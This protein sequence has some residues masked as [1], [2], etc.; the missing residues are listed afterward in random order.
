MKLKSIIFSILLSVSTLYIQGQN[1]ELFSKLSE[2]KYITS[3]I[4]SKAMLKMIP[5]I[6]ANIGVSGLNAKNL[7]QKLERVEIYTTETKV[8][9]NL[10]KKETS[11]LLKDKSY[12]TLMSVKDED[13]SINFF[14]KAGKGDI[15][16]E[17][18]MTV[19]EMDEYTI[20]R[21]LGNFTIDDIQNLISD[22]SKGKK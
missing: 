1:K 21:I 12:E 16:N 19:D 5:D 4:V 11:S 20:I 17:M 3:V 9:V 18:I 14:I 6:D 2:D 15:I 7:I 10:I 8:S 22:K 13:E